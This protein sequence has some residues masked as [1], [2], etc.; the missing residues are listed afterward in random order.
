[1]AVINTSEKYR[2]Y[3]LS[4]VVVV[5]SLLLRLVPPPDKYGLNMKEIDY[6]RWIRNLSGYDYFINCAANHH[7]FLPPMLLKYWLLI[8]PDGN[9][10]LFARLLS[11]IIFLLLLLVLLTIKGE[12]FDR[13]TR[14]LSAFMLSV[15]G[16]LI[17][18][19]RNARLLPLF[20]LS[21]F[22]FSFFLYRNLRNCNL[23][24]SIFLFLF[25]L[26]SLVTQP[27]SVIFMGA[28]LLGG[29]VVFRNAGIFLKCLLPLIAAV[30]VVSPY[31]FWLFYF[32]KAES[33]LFPVNLK[34]MTRW[35]YNLFDDFDTILLVLFAAVVSTHIREILNILKEC[36]NNTL[37]RFFLFGLLFCFLSLVMI[38]VFLPLTRIYYIIPLIAFSSVLA[39]FVLSRLSLKVIWIIVVLL[40]IK[41]F[42][43]Y[44]IFEKQVFAFWPSYGIEKNILKEFRNSGSYKEIDISKSVFINL[45]IYHTRAFDYYKAPEESYFP[46]MDKFG[47]VED[48]INPEYLIADAMTKDF[49]LILWENCERHKD[50]YQKKVCLLNMDIL[51]KNFEKSQIWEFHF[52]KKK[53]VI[54]VFRLKKRDRETTG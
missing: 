43:S 53:K 51:D 52:T 12:E 2:Y 38:S 35:F 50:L 49:Y 45:P 11:L 19:S 27:I 21:F 31:Y 18:F 7:G 20:V 15:N 47:Y 37:F 16:M 17:A 44:A 9:T 22:L 32:G 40:A 34:I 3:F 1:M 25:S 4:A 28:V 5:F 10:D 26:L 23:R 36:Y 39:G 6:I 48:I 46:P 24:D 41:A 30:I 42:L 8:M 54:R 29:I 13:K 14:L 33:E